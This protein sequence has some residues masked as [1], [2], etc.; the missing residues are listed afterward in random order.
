MFRDY[1]S[2]SELL[3]QAMGAE[4]AALRK[5]EADFLA[6]QEAGDVL[7]FVEVYLGQDEVGIGKLFYQCMAK[8]ME[9]GQSSFI[10]DVVRILKDQGEEKIE[11]L[12]LQQGVNVGDCDFVAGAIRALEIAD[13]SNEGGGVMGMIRRYANDIGRYEVLERID[14]SYAAMPG[15]FGQMV[16]SLDG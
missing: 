11:F 3:R 4:N 1:G 10:A 12:L 14:E 6:F 9:N 2:S 16:L 15:P 7:G 8:A 13:E 5:V